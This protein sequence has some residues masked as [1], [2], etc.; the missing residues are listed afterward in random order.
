MLQM[1]QI[2]A[3][4]LSKFEI[5]SD[6]GQ[7][8]F[9]F[10]LAWKALKQQEA[11]GVQAIPVDEARVLGRMV[12]SRLL[13]LYV[14]GQSSWEGPFQTQEHQKE[15]QA[16][17]FEK[18]LDIFK[19]K[20]FSKVFS[21]DEICRISDRL[22]KVDWVGEDLKLIVWTG[23]TTK[24]VPLSSL[25]PVQ[26]PGLEEVK[27]HFPSGCLWISDMFRQSTF[28]DWMRR[29]NPATDKNGIEALASSIRKMAQLGCVHVFVG[30]SSPS[31]FQTSKG[32]LWIGA[33]G[34]RPLAQ[35]EKEIG[36]VCTD[37]WRVT[38]IDEGCM[39]DILI[40]EVGE[41]K[42]LQLLEQYQQEGGFIKTQIEPG[43][44][45][46]TFAATPTIFKNGVKG[47]EVP[48]WEKEDR[49]MFTLTRK[50]WLR[51]AVKPEASPLSTPF[52]LK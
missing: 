50:S 46:L 29:H 25:P 9:D 33:L 24:W 3:G 34:E 23:R 43:D 36:R 32:E 2:M 28:M 44:Y 52:K 17:F 31:V 51:A 26:P 13:A 10:L 30:N 5:P 21:R 14:M 16:N 6:I 11:L 38:L 40:G 27:I 35:D 18:S 47:L 22:I 4:L 45:L 42:A 19:K 48:L 7:P 12:W 1:G 39:R 8:E 49:P 37:L 41:E 15:A 20:D